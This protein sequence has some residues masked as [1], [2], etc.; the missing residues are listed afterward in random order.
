MVKHIVL[1]VLTILSTYFVGG[2]LY[3]IA[4]MSIL[5]AHEMGHYCMSRRYGIP[6]TLPFFIPFPFSPFGTFGAII[7]MRGVVINKK[8]LFDVGAAGPLSGFIVAVPCVLIGMKMSTVGAATPNAEYLRLGDPLLF[9]ILEWLII[10]PLPGQE[11]FLHPIG[12]AGWVGLFV[13]ALNLLPVGQLDGGHIIYS[14]FGEKSRW[15]YG[16]SIAALVALTVLYNPGWLA[17]IVLLL[18]FGMRHPRPFDEETPL[19]RKRKIIAGVVLLVFILS[20]TP[21][22]FPDLNPHLFGKHGLF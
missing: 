19:D 4:I 18:I 16:L 8:A 5:L 21:A 10:K 20:F 2:A 17:L 13:T 1:F 7:K 9:K 6:S 22:P 15:A 11:V 3:S 14:V 12:Y